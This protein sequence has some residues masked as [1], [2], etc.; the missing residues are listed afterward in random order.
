MRNTDP[1]FTHQVEFAHKYL[2]NDPLIR[3]CHLCS[4]VIPLVL[5]GYKKIKNPF[6]NVDAH[7]GVLLY[8]LGLKEF[9]YYTVVFA[10]SRSLGCL[11]WL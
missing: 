10:V 1:R 7:S 11:A 8:T 4:E 5:E 2:A 6:P 9:E 3:L